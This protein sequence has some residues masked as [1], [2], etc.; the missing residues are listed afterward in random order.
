VEICWTVE[1]TDATTGDAGDEPARLVAASRG[2][3]QRAFSKLVRLHERQL[4]RVAG[5]FFR[6]REDVEDAAQESFLIAWRKLATYKAKAPFEY[7]LARICLNVCYGKLR[8]QRAVNVPLEIDVAAERRDPDASIEVERL[9]RPLKPEDR[10]VLLLLDG[11][12]W[13]TREI[14]E[15]LGWSKSNVKVRAHRARKRLRALLEPTR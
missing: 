3:D 11:E 14:A 15:R 1:M 8:R 2:G 4:F 9:L 12:G 13:S 6:A 5:R 7:W 10:F